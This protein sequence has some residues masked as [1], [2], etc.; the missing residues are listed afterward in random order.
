MCIGIGRPHSKFKYSLNIDDPW[1][2]K[3]KMKNWNSVLWQDNLLERDFDGL[4]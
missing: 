3:G 4:Q 1:S 2:G